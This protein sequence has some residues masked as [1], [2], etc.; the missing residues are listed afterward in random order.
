MDNLAIDIKD[1]RICYRNLE[2]T[3]LLESL[4]HPGKSRLGVTEAVKG[5]SFSVPHGQI[6]GMVGSNGSGKTTTLLA[7]AGIFQPDSGVINT[8]GHTVSLLALGVGFHKELTGRENILLSGMLMGF[9][10]QQIHAHMEQ[11]VDFSE[12][13]AAIDKPVRTYSSGMKSKL[14]FSI[15]SSLQTDIILIDEVLSVG[16]ERFRRKC[17]ERMK[18]L[19][20]DDDRT[21][22]IVSHSQGTIREMCSSVIWLENGRVRM[23]GDTKT[24]LEAYTDFMLNETDD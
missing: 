20:Y 10:H 6:V 22:I 21:V 3:S 12:L 24:V 1:L 7:I 16:D 4:F 19:I 11:I 23:T 2:A 9:P 18:E 13:G 14:A 15:T 5:V 17:N 8:F